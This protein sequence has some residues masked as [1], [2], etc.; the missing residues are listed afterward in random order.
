MSSALML[1]KLVTLLAERRLAVDTPLHIQRAAME[2]AVAKTPL[3]P[4]V[5]VTP[6]T[7]ATRPCERFEPSGSRG[8][9]TILYF[10]GGGYVLGSLASIRPFASYLAA[11]TSRTVITLDYRLAPEHPYPAAVDDVLAAYSALRDDH[12]LACHEIV[13]AGDS[14]G[15]GLV[16]SALMTLR[17]EGTALPAAGVCLS[18]WTDLTLTAPSLQTNAA[19]DPQITVDGLSMMADHYCQDTD[20]TVPGVS[21]RFGRFD[22]LP[23]LLIQVGDAEGLLDD[24]VHA[25]AEAKN[26]G[27]AVTLDV[28][29]DM[30]HVWQAFAPRFPPAMDALAKIGAWLD[31]LDVNG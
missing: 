10:H 14:A 2:Q 22:E 26:A 6:V 15:G 20:R 30:I 17:D 21:P 4:D 24:S 9:Q 28:W 19:T 23:P 12:H 31:Q 16:L 3:A 11:A 18:P 8:P 5:T 27:V 29:P 13:F 1:K 25:A 7:L